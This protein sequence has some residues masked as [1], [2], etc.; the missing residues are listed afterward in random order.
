MDW[1]LIRSFFFKYQIVDQEIYLNRKRRHIYLA[2][3]TDPEVMG[4]SCF[5]LVFGIY[6]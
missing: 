6:L 2:L 5:K 4:S 3:S 1:L